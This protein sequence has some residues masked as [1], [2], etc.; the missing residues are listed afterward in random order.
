MNTDKKSFIRRYANTVYVGGVNMKQFSVDIHCK[1]TCIAIM[2]RGYCYS[3]NSTNRN[4]FELLEAFIK[5]HPDMQFV[6]VNVYNERHTK[7]LSTAQL[8]DGVKFIG[9]PSETTNIFKYKAV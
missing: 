1:E 8:F 9:I 6:R 3:I 7:L 2:N 5:K 4:A